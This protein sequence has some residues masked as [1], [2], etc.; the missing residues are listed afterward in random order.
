MTPADLRSTLATLAP[1]GLTARRLAALWGYRSDNS[2]H[3]WLRGES[4]VPP[5]IASWLRQAEAWW[6]ANRPTP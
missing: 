1:L 4:P 3:K 5:H 2:V 6:E